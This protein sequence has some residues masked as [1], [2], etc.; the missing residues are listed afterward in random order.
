MKSIWGQDEKRIKECLD[1]EVKA[2]C[3]IDHPRVCIVEHFFD[4][5]EEVIVLEKDHL[6]KV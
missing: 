6:P 3:F 1:V 5:T 4:F 2:F